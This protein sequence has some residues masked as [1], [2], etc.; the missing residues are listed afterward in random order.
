MASRALTQGTYANAKHEGAANNAPDPHAES[1]TYSSG[2]VR[3]ASTKHPVD[4]R[5]TWCFSTTRPEA[6]QWQLWN[7]IN[8]LALWQADCNMH[9]R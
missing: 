1:L 9:R 4:D 2:A 8:G 6:A 7:G 5:Q 3:G